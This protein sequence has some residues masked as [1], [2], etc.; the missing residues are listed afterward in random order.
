M[1]LRQGP[2]FTHHIKS[3]PLLWSSHGNEYNNLCHLECDPAYSGRYVGL[4][5][6]WRNV[7]N[8]LPYYKAS[9]SG[10]QQTWSFLFFLISWR[11]SGGR[12]RQT[13]TMTKL[14]Y[15]KSLWKTKFSC[16]SNCIYYFTFLY[17]I[18]VVTMKELT[19]HYTNTNIATS[20]D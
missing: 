1:K 13:Y 2:N 9:C 18:Y 8:Y 12:D 11:V 19:V 16:A 3:G 7:G 17:E 4:S 15:S 14:S 10:R 5:T 20:C 6:S